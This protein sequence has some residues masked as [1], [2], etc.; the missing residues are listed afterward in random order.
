H[1]TGGNWPQTLKESPLN[2]DFYVLRER[3]LDELFPWDF[4]DHGIKK[5]FL[6]KEY[7]KGIKAKTSPPCPMESCNI[8]GVCTEATQKT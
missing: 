1:K 4:I 8:C 6:K 5:S 3:S 2:P 7:K